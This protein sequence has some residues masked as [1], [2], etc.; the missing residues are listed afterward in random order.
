VI[1]DYNKP[2]LKKTISAQNN[3]LTI[4]KK[5]KKYNFFKWQLKSKGLSAMEIPQHGNGPKVS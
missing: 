2:W 1:I 5:R 4:R 3:E